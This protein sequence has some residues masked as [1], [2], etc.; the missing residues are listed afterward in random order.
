MKPIFTLIAACTS[1]LSLLLVQACTTPERNIPIAGQMKTLQGH[2]F[3]QQETSI[4]QNAFLHLSLKDVVSNKVISTAT[5]PAPTHFPSTF[6]LEYAAKKLSNNNA[7]TLES[8]ITSNN[9][10]LLTSSQSISAQHSSST[11]I[12][13]Q[14]V[15]HQQWLTTKQWQLVSLANITIQPNTET[16]PIYLQMSQDTNILGFAGCNTFR[17]TYTLNS[18][19][20]PT[21]TLTFGQVMSSRMMCP[22]IDIE[23]KLLKALRESQHYT[24]TLNSLFLIG[25]NG[26]EL[27]HFSLK[28]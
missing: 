13:L 4:P 5:M 3:Y 1:L 24:V 23:Q 11:E 16:S 2:I 8:V 19:V 21:P 14:P 6:S 28:K 12:H 9:S 22:N 7:Y 25:A 10:L 20:P 27:A 15:N 17:G 18:S 26:A